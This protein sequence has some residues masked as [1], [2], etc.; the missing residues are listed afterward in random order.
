MAELK[1]TQYNSPSENNPGPYE[2]IVV[3]HL[4]PQ[5]M[6]AL[7]VELLKRGEAG[8]QPERTGQVV[9]VRYMSPFYGVTPVSDNS[10]ND[11]YEYT[12][13]SYGMWMVPPDVGTRVLVIFVQGDIS[14]GYWIGCIQD[15]YMNFMVPGYAST[16][17]TTDQTPSAYKGKPLPAAE[18]NKVV[19]TGTATD[20]TFFKKPFHKEFTAALEQQ[21]L[22]DDYVRGTTTSS[23]RREVPSAVFGISTPGPKDKRTGAPRGKYGSSEA[24]AD[25]FSNRLGGSSFVMDDGDDKL[26]RKGPASTTKREYAN[27]ELG[28]QGGDPSL[29]HNEH[30]RIRTRTGHQ[31]LLHNTEDLIYIGNARGTAWIELTS[32]GKIDIFAQDSISVHTAADFNFYADRD[33]N[34]NANENINISAGKDILVEAGDNIDITAGKH[35]ATNAGTDLSLN[36]GTFTSIYAVNSMSLTTQDR[37][38]MVSSGNMNIGTLGQLHVDA[39][40]ALYINTDGEMHTNALGNMITNTNASYSLNATADMLVNTNAAYNL[41]AAADIKTKS[42][43]S[44]L[45]TSG[46]TTEMLAG[47]EFK[48]TGTK[49]HLNG[50]TATDS[51][52]SAVLGVTVPVAPEPTMPTAPQQPELISRVPQHEPWLQHENLDPEAFT[53]LKTRAGQSANNI[54]SPRVPDTFRKSGGSLTAPIVD[55][56]GTPS[57]YGSTMPTGSQTFTSSSVPR[58]P[59]VPPVPESA[60]QERTVVSRVFS[61]Y[62]AE[63]GFGREEIRAAIACAVE[64]SGLDYT[65]VEGYY[66]SDPAR[67][68]TFFRSSLGSKT[69]AEIIALRDAGRGAWF[70]VVYGHTTRKGRD[71]GNVVPG[72]G[73]LYSGRGMIQLTGRYNFNKYGKLA[74]LVDESLIQPDRNLPKYNPEGVMII[75]DPLILSTDLDKSMQVMAAYL[76]DAY[77]DRGRSIVANM[78]LCINPYAPDEVFQK[79]IQHL[80]QIDDSYLDPSIA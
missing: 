79:D 76:K 54:F 40:G 15:Q 1:R 62:L 64:E 38:D 47:S 19:E 36:S 27:V 8:N 28:E 69:D 32:N 48:V 66:Y 49:V 13:K 72:D 75:D 25:V 59:D 78:R 39:C 53:P 30:V 21:G 24:R 2:A 33:I 12:Q 58:V 16:E 73:G 65:K 70:E 31:I 17:L 60:R 44:S 71:L 22:I 55:E 51:A 57:I 20:P 50:P 56:T 10:R 34:L 3:S 61:K 14:R 80:A 35:F 4:D 29:P 6:G 67:A 37:L 43:G 9:E 46:G 11:G 68:R 74:G 5:Y 18:Y 26:L 23:A 42:G 77:R 63:A 41:N 45:I 52:P 7:Q